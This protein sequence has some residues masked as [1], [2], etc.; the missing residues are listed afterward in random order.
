MP[1]FPLSD[2]VLKGIIQLQLKRIADR[3][4]ENHRATL[5]YADNVVSTIASRCKEVESGAR[6]V[7]HILNGNSFLPAIAGQFLGLHGGGQTGEQGP[8]L[9]WM[10][11]VNSLTR[12]DKAEQAVA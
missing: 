8:S 11:R 5:T 12:F 4:R 7:D 2:D 10:K 1:Y 3:V 9:Q 6:S